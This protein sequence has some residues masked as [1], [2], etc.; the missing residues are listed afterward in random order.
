M[1][2]GLRELCR[3]SR[4]IYS[5]SREK[6]MVWIQ[7]R[8]IY[9][10]EDSKELLRYLDILGSGEFLGVQNGYGIFRMFNEFDC[11]WGWDGEIEVGKSKEFR[12]SYGVVSNYFGKRSV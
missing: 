6:S 8:N 11:V 1:F 7:R 10:L 12:L 4:F 5:D 3:G 9:I 2:W